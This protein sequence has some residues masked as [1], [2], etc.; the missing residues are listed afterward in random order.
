VKSEAVAVP[1]AIKKA[2]VAK[3]PV[4]PK[5]VSQKTVS[6]KDTKTMTD[7]FQAGSWRKSNGRVQ[8]R[9]SPCKDSHGKGHRPDQ[10]RCCVQQGQC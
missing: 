7:T 10:G 6:I 4:A 2:R 8:G 1:A 5:S 9:C 3:T